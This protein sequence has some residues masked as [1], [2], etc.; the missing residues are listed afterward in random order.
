MQISGNKIVTFDFTVMDEQGQL[1]ESSKDTG[2]MSYLHGAGKIAAGLE[3]ALEGR[4]SGDTFSVLLT[5]SQGFGERD[6]SL[7][8]TFTKEELAGLGE[9]K[10]GMQ[11]QSKDDDGI[12]TLTITKIEDDKVILDE[13]H[14]LAG[15]LVTFDVTV[16][17]VRKATEDELGYEPSQSVR[18]ADDCPTC[19]S[20]TSEYG[21]DHD[22]ECGG[23][24]GHH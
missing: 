4:S 22:C 24:C 15:K 21:N 16:I 13:N 9:L 12:R 8:H 19:G 7:I 11:L 3:K 1:I 23:D 2:S 14:P 20:S 18:Y 17:D 5:P 6:D 10:T